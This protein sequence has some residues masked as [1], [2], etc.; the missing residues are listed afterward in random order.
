MTQ[1]KFTEACKALNKAARVL[2]ATGGNF[3]RYAPLLEL[4]GITS[5]LQSMQRGE[6]PDFISQV[7]ADQTQAEL[8]HTLYNG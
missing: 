4:M 8:L 5:L 6:I 7:D 3:V 2:P 1:K